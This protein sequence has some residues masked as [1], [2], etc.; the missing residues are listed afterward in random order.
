MR[1]QQ[2]LYN[3]TRPQV[4]EEDSDLLSG[5]HNVTRYTGSIAE[6]KNPG[7]FFVLCFISVVTFLG[8]LLVIVAVLRD[9]ALHTPTN[10]LILSLA[11]SKWLKCTIGYY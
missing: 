9:R 7:V 2:L 1:L 4:M 8:N 3:I 10:F 6:M 11:G 5:G